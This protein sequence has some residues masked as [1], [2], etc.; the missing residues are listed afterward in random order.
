MTAPRGHPGGIR[1]SG[2]V[3]IP[4]ILSVPP[5]APRGTQAAQGNMEQMQLSEFAFS[6]KQ[7]RRPTGQ[8]LS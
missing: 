6:G 1:S 7:I 5:G 3:Q 4:P 8:S 2:D